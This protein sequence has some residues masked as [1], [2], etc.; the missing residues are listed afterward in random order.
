MGA[1]RFFAV[2]L[3][4]GVG[5]SM[6]ACTDQGNPVEPGSS[7]PPSASGAGVPKPTAEA[8]AAAV[9]PVIVVAG[10]DVDGEH[11]SASGYVSG[12]IEDGGECTFTFSHAV[13]ATSVVATSSGTADRSTTSCGLVS[14]EIA[15]FI[16]G[17]WTV[18]LDYESLNGEVSHSENAELVVP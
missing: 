8:T 10:V 5:M 15:S 13:D 16:S 9:E 18:Q 12:V 14:T 11:V 4:A 3:A 17:Q 2:I 7:T 1:P 6:L